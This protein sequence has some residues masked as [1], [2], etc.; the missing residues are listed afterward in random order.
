[1]TSPL[2]LVSE[3]MQK[4]SDAVSDAKADATLSGP[5]R[6]SSTYGLGG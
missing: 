6:P 1:L 5:R 3:V 2:E 4:A